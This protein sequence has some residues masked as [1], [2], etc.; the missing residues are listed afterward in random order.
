MSA[1][2]H[3]QLDLPIAAEVVVGDAGVRVPHQQQTELVHSQ[4][5]GILQALLLHF[6]LVVGL[7][8]VDSCE[9]LQVELLETVVNDRQQL[10]AV[11]DEFLAA[12]LPVDV[13]VDHAETARAAIVKT[14]VD[15]AE[16]EQHVEEVAVKKVAGVNFLIQLALHSAVLDVVVEEQPLACQH[17]NIL[18]EEAHVVEWCAFAAD[19]LYQ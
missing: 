3:L 7:A 19:E 4:Q 17:E 18:V 16:D 1:R 15:L 2:K 9:V 6:V 5:H 10:L 12:G 8:A 13:A 11:T 14:G